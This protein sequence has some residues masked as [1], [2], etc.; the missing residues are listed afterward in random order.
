MTKN[1]LVYVLILNWNGREITIDCVKSVLKSNYPN[2]KIVVIDNGSTDKSVLALREIFGE[3]VEIIE[4]QQNLGYA[5]GFNVGL[6][7]GFVDNAADYCL[8]M[9]NDTIIDT[10]AISELVKIA[11]TDAKI[12]FATGKVY[13]YDNPNILQ[14]VGKKDDTIRW[15][16]GHIGNREVDNG[17]YDEIC[18][19]YFAD[20]I[21]TLVSGRLYRATGGYDP[22]FFLQSEDYD[23]QARAKR[24]G[25]KI[26][27]TPYA[28]LW[29]KDS[30]TI[31]RTSALKAYYDARNPMLVI[32]IHKSP[33][34]FRNYL[35]L[36]FFKDILMGSLVALKHGRVTKALAQWQGL[37]SGI[38]WGI[39]N[40]K[41]TLAHFLYDY[42]EQ[43]TS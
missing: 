7:Y 8:I 13:Y 24:F 5:M 31:G 22:T 16:G 29:H 4:N 20:D 42:R 36:H 32:L 25:Y 35:R 12:G 15:N 2:F 14:T 41:F 37:F 21:Y 10:S 11:S 3:S 43:K 19:R 23:W 28:R 9:N 34:F 18:E 30:M 26:M 6:K 39:R 33:E 40:R 27:Y 1:P 38:I 17:Q